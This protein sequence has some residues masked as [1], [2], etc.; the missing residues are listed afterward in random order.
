MN[1]VY[2]SEIEASSLI[3]LIYDVEE[4]EVCLWDCGMYQSEGANYYLSDLE[5]NPFPFKQTLNQLV[6]RKRFIYPTKKD[7]AGLKKLLYRFGIRY[8]K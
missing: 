3:R 7:D 5:G 2:L 4:K 6:I 8:Q 1:P